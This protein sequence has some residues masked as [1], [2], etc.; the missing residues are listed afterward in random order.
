MFLSQ[1]KSSKVSASLWIS[2]IKWMGDWVIKC[3]KIYKSSNH[4]QT[5]LPN[6]KRSVTKSHLILNTHSDTC[7]NFPALFILMSGWQEETHVSEGEMFCFIS[8]FIRLDSQNCDLRL[9]KD[10]KREH[11]DIVR[12][13]KCLLPRY[14]L[15][16]VH[17]C[18]V[19]AISERRQK[20]S[21]F[22]DIARV[23]QPV[24]I[25]RQSRSFPS[26]L[27][28]SLRPVWQQRKKLWRAIKILN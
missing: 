20:V 17:C 1:Q 16:N 14:L 21:D 25:D 27:I 13:I 12:I 8:I 4:S 6:Q 11:Y 2:L 5:T 22:T 15:D 7:Q 28:V 23:V 19:G 18:S 3:V 9:L 26:I 10:G 24:R